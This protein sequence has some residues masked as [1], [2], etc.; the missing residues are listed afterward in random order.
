MKKH[1]GKYYLEPQEIQEAIAY[2]I[3]RNTGE[4]VNKEDIAFDVI[5]KEV[6][7]SSP[8]DDVIAWT[9]TLQGAYAKKTTSKT[10]NRKTAKT[11]FGGNKWT[12]GKRMDL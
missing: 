10:P 2:Y 1:K 3:E 7:Q 9:P 6:L 5:D 4:V 12:L 8:Y 11:N